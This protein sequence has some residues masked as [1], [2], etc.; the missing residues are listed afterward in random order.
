M[1]LFQQMLL[2]DVEVNTGVA[3]NPV[4]MG[5][6]FPIQEQ[7]EIWYRFIFCCI[8]EG[9]QPPQGYENWDVKSCKEFCRMHGLDYGKMFEEN[10]EEKIC[11]TRHR[12]KK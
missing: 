3:Y 10:G 1:N 11:F 12:N 8:Q 5:L 2:Y 6:F 7:P 4:I 9:M